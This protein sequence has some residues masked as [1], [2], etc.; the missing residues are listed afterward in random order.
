MNEESECK[1][2]QYSGTY[3]KL[4]CFD[5]LSKAYSLIRCSFPTLSL[6]IAFLSLCVSYRAPS[7][8]NCERDVT[9][10]KH[11]TSDL[12]ASPG[13]GVSQRG[14]FLAKPGLHRVLH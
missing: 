8:L 6:T 10:S 14:H 13:T 12:G 1:G 7:D 3:K 11:H 9:R 2:M 4:K 5:V